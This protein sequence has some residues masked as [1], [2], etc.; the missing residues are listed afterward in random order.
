M[1]IGQ[2]CSS[3]RAALQEAKAA[4]IV[5]IGVGGNDCD[6]DGGAKEFTATTQ[7]LADLTSEEWWRQMGALQADWIIGKT[8]GKA[9]VLSLK[10]TDAT[11]GAWLQDG[12]ESELATCADCAVVETLEIANQDV[13]GGT[14]PAKFST[15][16]LQNADVNAVNVPLDGWFLAGVAQAIQA[17]G[18]S[19]DL[20]AIGAFGELG[21][22]D[23]IRSGTGQDAS[24]GFSAAW[25]GWAAIDTTIR[26]LNG[27][28]VEAEGVGLQVID[29]DT[30]M[31]AA[32]EP[33]A[34][35]P[36]VDYVAAFSE[37]WGIG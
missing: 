34:Y 25:D 3:F 11:F 26:V 36:A 24:V 21:N 27:E 28:E 37:L 32:G 20:A 18:R 5:T 8:D 9:Q 30:N 6:V 33:F 13:G 12:F 4:D 31:P 29:A 2:D 15:A 1:Q 22:L 35:E 16:L 7:K 19:D 17:S 10:F 23:L 14:L